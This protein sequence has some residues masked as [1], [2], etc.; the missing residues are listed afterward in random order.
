MQKYTFL[1]ELTSKQYTF[2][3]ELLSKYNTFLGELTSSTPIEVTT[4]YT[5]SCQKRLHI[6]H[7]NIVQRVKMCYKIKIDSR[8]LVC[9]FYGVLLCKQHP[10]HTIAPLLHSNSATIRQ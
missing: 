4:L 3:G 8:D 5:Y 1:G 7:A 10:S 6:H 2:L 9:C